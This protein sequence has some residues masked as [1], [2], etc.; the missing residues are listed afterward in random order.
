M[1]FK[2]H[3]LNFLTLLIASILGM[4][5]LDAQPNEFLHRESFL[6][7]ISLPKE[8][9]TLLNK[10][11]A[12]ENNRG[13]VYHQLAGSF[14]KTNW[15]T[16]KKRFEVGVEGNNLY[17]A[18]IQTKYMGDYQSTAIISGNN[19]ALVVGKP[20]VL[21][22]ERRDFLV[23]SGRT[24]C[25]GGAH[26]ISVVN[27]N[28]KVVCETSISED[29]ALES[30]IASNFLSTPLKFIKWMDE[31]NCEFNWDELKM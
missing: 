11:L 2:Q 27:E 16:I 19:I 15:S 24:P 23:A 10:K 3:Y 8:V 30:K 29:N 21:K 13:T 28:G 25:C 20:M 17:F 31:E 6:P 9:V 1:S 7:Q 4:E 12:E 5:K 22:G 26:V 18:S 14:S